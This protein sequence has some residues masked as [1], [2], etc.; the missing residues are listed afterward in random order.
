MSSAVG[1]VLVVLLLA[2]NVVALLATLRAR[3]QSGRAALEQAARRCRYGLQAVCIGF[4]I[5]V[6]HAGWGILRYM[7]ATTDD[8]EAVLLSAAF[9]DALDHTALLLLAVLL[10]SACIIYLNVRLRRAPRELPKEEEG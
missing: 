9:S 4:L 8:Q 5:T 1:W 3:K 2:G 7:S 10:P 6:V